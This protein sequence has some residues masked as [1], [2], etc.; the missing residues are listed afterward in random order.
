M[1]PG[2]W[3]TALAAMAV[4]M[5]VPET[6]AQPAGKAAG[7]AGGAVG[8]AVA[9]PAPAR[10]SLWNGYERIDFEWAGR[11]CV[12]VQ[13]KEAAPG[14]PWIWRTEFFDHQP[15]VDL[16]LL[17]KGWHVAY[18]NAKDLYGSPRAIALFNE[19]YAHLVIHAGLAKRPVL[20]G[21]SR[22]GLYAANFAAT[23]PTRVAALYLDAPVLDLRSWPGR[24]RSSREWT[25]M[26]EAYGLTEE[27]FATF[28]GNP[29]DKVDRLAAAKIPVIIVAG[30]ADDVVPYAENGGVLEKRYRAAGV[31][32]Q[33]IL[34]PGGGHH[35]HSLPDP[36]PVVDF[37]L[38]NAR[39]D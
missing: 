3:K 16:A 19:F 10:R 25:Q 37:L 21:F 15:Q 2:R 39:T 35:P 33:A 17:G 29:V 28:R 38:A 23:H 36:T 22:G 7:K 11:P 6:T 8:P 12:L 1:N 4:A 34:K 30:D 9:A 26:L 31:A 24:N 32:F 5:A 13:P 18:M 14:K 27:K 20:E